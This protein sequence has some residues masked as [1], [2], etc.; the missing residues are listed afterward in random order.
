MQIIV[1]SNKLLPHVLSGDGERG[2][3]GLDSMVSS[4]PGAAFCCTQRF[5]DDADRMHAK[6]QTNTPLEATCLVLD[7]FKLAWWPA[8]ASLY[9]LSYNS[10]YVFLIYY[11]NILK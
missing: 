3:M 10:I 8:K 7:Y 6:M 1:T 5:A 11:S 2:V 9:F 4:I